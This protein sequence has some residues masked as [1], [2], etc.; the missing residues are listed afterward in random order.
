MPKV[1]RTPSG[2]H[3][4]RKTLV[5]TRTADGEWI[6]RGWIRPIVWC[7]VDY[8]STMLDPITGDYATAEKA[9][10]DATKVLEN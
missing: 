2:R 4:A 6:P 7:V 10:L 3:R 8:G 5:E 9:L 1:R